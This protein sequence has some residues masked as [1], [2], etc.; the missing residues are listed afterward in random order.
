MSTLNF[1]LK[2]DTVS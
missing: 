1:T 2:C